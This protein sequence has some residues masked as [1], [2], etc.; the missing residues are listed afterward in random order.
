MPASTIL[1]LESADAGAKSLAP[2]LTTSGY[3]VTRT[4]D[5]D[6]AFAKVAENQLA[7]IDFG[8]MAKGAKT[9]F[10]LCRE[11]RATPSLAPI[12][13]LCVAASDDVEERISFLEAGADDVVARPF[14]GREVEARV[15]ALLLRFQR[16][17]EL[18]PV[19]SA[20]GLTLA[21]PRRTVAVYSPKGGVGTTTIATNIAVAAAQR[22]V[23]RVILVD[24]D[25]QFGG[26]ASHLNLE[27]K[28]TLV[29][30]VRDVSAMREHELLKSYAVRHDSG[31]HVLA[32]P[33]TPESAE[34]ITPDHV[35]HILGTLLEGYDAIVV[36]AGSVL[37]E[38][39]LRVFEAAETIVL[40]VHPEMSALKAV[41]GLLDYLNEAGSIG[42]KSTFVLNNMFAREVLK[43][44]DIESAL[45][46]RIS[47]DLPYDPFLYLKA[48]NEGVPI[49]LGAP[50]SPAAEHLVKLSATAFGA[51][52]YIVPAGQVEKKPRRFGFGR[53][54]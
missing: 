41:H 21:K 12:P 5:P 20:D 37:D 23:D 38:R 4:N 16:S 36:D 26:V 9:A 29:D 30:V 19:V 8:K 7:I 48:V 44:R 1:V 49:V 43:L 40:P 33:P 27:P 10:D 54:N 32:A 13:I 18:A 53:R 15:E 35:S 42:A 11:I 51:D 50:R 17:R 39:V 31:L 6:E 28:Q 34:L 2:I 52:G 22:R 24:L 45:G 25:L 14:D 3:T 46:T 47:A